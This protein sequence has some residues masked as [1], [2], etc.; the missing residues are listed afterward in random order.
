MFFG[1]TRKT[2]LLLFITSFRKYLQEKQIFFIVDHVHVRFTWTLAGFCPTMQK[3]VGDIVWGAFVGWR[4]SVY[5]LNTLINMYLSI[6]LRYLDETND[7]G[8]ISVFVSCLY[9]ACP[10]KKYK[11]NVSDNFKT[12]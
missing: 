6:S 12:C 3:L 9:T 4:M 8:C 7:V 10:E 2:S 1:A 11:P 5:R